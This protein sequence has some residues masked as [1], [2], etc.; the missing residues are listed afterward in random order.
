MNDLLRRL[1]VMVKQSWATDCEVEA[2]AELRR[3]QAENEALKAALQAPRT[4]EWERLTEL[5]C[6]YSD[7]RAEVEALRA[8]AERYRWLAREHGWWLLKHFPAVRPYVDA[9]EVIDESIDAAMEES[10]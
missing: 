5:K 7:L 8:D 4:G 3:L 1:D 10:K 9:S 6:A 2:A